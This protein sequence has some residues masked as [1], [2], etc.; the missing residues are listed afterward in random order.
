MFGQAEENQSPEEYDLSDV[1]TSGELIAVTLSGPDTYY[2]Y[3][4]QGFGLQFAMAEAFARSIGARLRMEMASDTVELFQRLLNG[5]ADMIALELDSTSLLHY[6]GRQAILLKSHWVLRS[7]SED[8]A[9]A[10]DDWWKPN[11]RDRFL[12]AENSTRASRSSIRRHV[13]PPMLSRASGTISAYDA[14]FIRHAQSIGWDW[15]LLAAQCY[16]ESGFDPNAVSWAGAKGLMQIM[17][18]TADRLGISRADMTD[19]NTNIEGGV[20]YLAQLNH[21]FSDIRSRQERISFILAAYNGGAGHVRDAM[22]LAQQAGRNI[23]HWREVEP[24]ILALSQ[25]ENY[26]KRVVKYGYLRGE[27]TVEYV[28]QIRRR[29]ASYSGSARPHYMAPQP[30][31][32]NRSPSRVKPR[33]EFIN[34]TIKP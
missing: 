26:R 11:T 12:A 22:A 5:E 17:P 6:A 18:T 19:P 25:P 24:F 9:Q 4:G 14:L 8:L 31:N 21:S 29:W 20:R 3:R 16:Q 23:Q 33:S 27:E 10:V 28:R 34:D 2:E 32:S 7:S 13:R 15:R 30:K 1:Q